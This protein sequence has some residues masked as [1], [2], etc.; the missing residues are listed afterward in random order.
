MKAANSKD[1]GLLIAANELLI[2]IKKEANDGYQSRII[3]LEETKSEL[4][5]KL[6]EHTPR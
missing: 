1:K 5:A 4:R 2:N 6:R 3:L